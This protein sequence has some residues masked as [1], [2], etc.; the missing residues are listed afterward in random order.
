MWRLLSWNEGGEQ[1]GMRIA[2]VGAGISGLVAAYHLADEHELT[3]FEAN[4]YIGGHTNTVPVDDA[5]GRVYV[6][7]GFIVFN[8]SNYPNFSALLDVLGVESHPT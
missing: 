5:V 3:V 6:D 2:I 7:T 4:D 8:P 1:R